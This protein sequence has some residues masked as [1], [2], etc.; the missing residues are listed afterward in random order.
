[1]M[2]INFG[3]FNS[4]I[5][6]WIGVDHALRHIIVQRIPLIGFLLWKIRILNETQYDW[7]KRGR[8]K[9]VIY[10]DIRK[11]LKFETDSVDYIYSS[12][13]LEHLFKAEALLFLKECFRILKKEGKIRICLPDWESLKMQPS[14]ENSGFAKNQKEMKNSHKWAWTNKELTQVLRDIGFWGITECD[15]QGG[16]FPDIERLEHRRGLILQAQK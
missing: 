4:N 1:M 5:D 15:F 16:D 12:H 9:T 6:G 7:H 8:F 14:F 2:K 3:C 13:L 11:R 10:G